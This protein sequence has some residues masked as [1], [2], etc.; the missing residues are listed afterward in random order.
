MTNNEIM[1]GIRYAL[2]MKN[3]EVK[4]L[5]ELAGEEITLPEVVNL[6]KK[7]ELEGFERCTPEQLHAFLDGLIIKRRGKKDG[8]APK[9]N[10]SHINNNMIL[11]KLRIAFELRDTDVIATL[12]LTGFNMSKAELGAMSRRKS[13]H[14]Y[15]ACG[16]QVMRYFLKGL[17]IKYRPKNIG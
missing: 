3:A 7:E 5:F 2:H 13:H 14:Q 16:D 15:T 8:P 17:V 12:K 1:I 10:K 9:I 6:L 4:E 11:R